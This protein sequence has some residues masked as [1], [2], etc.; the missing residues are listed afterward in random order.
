MYVFLVLSQGLFVEGKAA[1][2]IATSF[3]RKMMVQGWEEGVFLHFLKY[4]DVNIEMI[5][6]A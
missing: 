4:Q 6:N 5:V 3:C 1:R 2:Y